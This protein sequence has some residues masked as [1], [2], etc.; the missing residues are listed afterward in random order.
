MPLTVARPLVRKDMSAVGDGGELLLVGVCI[1]R[2]VVLEL[3]LEWDSVWRGFPPN[4]RLVELLV[5]ARR[6]CLQ[7]GQRRRFISS[8]EEGVYCTKVTQRKS[9]FGCGWLA[10]AVLPI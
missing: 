10:D 2:E 9:C 8:V 4:D 5:I 6:A 1:C 3:D 7:E